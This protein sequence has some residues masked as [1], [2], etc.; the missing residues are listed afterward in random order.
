MAMEQL[1][2]AKAVSTDIAAAK[3]ENPELESSITTMFQIADDI[4]NKANS[5]FSMK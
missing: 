4:I 5:A 2:T 1:K 3:R